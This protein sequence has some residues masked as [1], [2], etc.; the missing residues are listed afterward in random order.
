MSE[1]RLITSESSGEEIAD[2]ALRPQ[3]L[4]DFVGQRQVR[5]NLSVFVEAAHKRDE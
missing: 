5:E 1:D 3:R 4:S 2:V